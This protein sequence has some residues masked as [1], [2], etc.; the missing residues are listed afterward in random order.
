MIEIKDRFTGEVIVSGDVSIKELVEINRANLCGANLIDANLCGANLCG[1][2]LID[3]N[4]CGA[5]LC[6]ANLIDANLRG[7]NLC[8]ANLCGANLEGEILTKTPIYIDLDW[9]VTITTEYMRIGCQRHTIVDWATFT[10][11]EISNM[12]SGALDFWNTWKKPLLA[13]CEAYKK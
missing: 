10:D 9:A 6:G 11:E 12:S 13:M 4:L 3:A 8:G 5:N 2:N 7:A 1:A